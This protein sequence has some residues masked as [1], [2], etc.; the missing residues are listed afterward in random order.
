M[1]ILTAKSQRSDD[2]GTKSSGKDA[3]QNKAKQRRSGAVM[4]AL[5]GR[6]CRCQ[7]AKDGQMASS[8][9]LTA[10]PPR[11]AWTPY[12]MTQKI[13]RMILRDLLVLALCKVQTAVK[14]CTGQ[15]LPWPSMHRSCRMLWYLVSLTNHGELLNE[16]RP[17]A[18]AMT[19]KGIE[20]WK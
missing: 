7:W 11:V 17:Y 4:S 2:S 16:G 8:M 18:R 19:G 13:P 15:D 14:R 10:L 9:H 12:R 1:A 6:L 5:A 20:Y 3:S